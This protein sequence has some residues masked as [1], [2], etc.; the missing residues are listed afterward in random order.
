MIVRPESKKLTYGV[1]MS[2][3]LDLMNGFMR[4]EERLQRREDKDWVS[5]LEAIRNLEQEEAAKEAALEQEWEAHLEAE[6]QKM[7]AVAD[8]E[9]AEKQEAKRK[10]DIRTSQ[11]KLLWAGAWAT[12]EQKPQEKKKKRKGKKGSE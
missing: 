3:M 7:L 6:R 4:D 10:D 5:E 9:F 11:T 8:P 12:A 1:K 2:F